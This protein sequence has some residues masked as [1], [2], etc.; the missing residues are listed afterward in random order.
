MV[1]IASITMNPAVDVSTTAPG[2]APTVKIRCS[3]PHVQ[4]GGGGINVAR[5]ATRF[6]AEA[7][8]LF[9]A[10]G[11]NGDHLSKLLKDEGVPIEPIP[12]A[13]DT[14]ESLTVTEAT[15]GDQYRFVFP[16]PTISP[17][18]EKRV[19]AA[20]DALAA[21][22]FLVVSGSLPSGLSAGFLATL[23][24]R[25]AATGAKLVVDGPAPVV[26]ASRGAFLVKPN[27]TELEDIVGA[28]LPDD[29][30]RVGAARRLIEQGIS[31]IVL[32]S[33]GSDGA[34]LVSDDAARLYTS[35]PVDLVSA[36]GAGDS[37]VGGLL[38]GLAHGASLEDAVAMGVAAGA[39]AILTPDTELCRPEDARRLLADVTSKP[40]A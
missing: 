28:P 38:V 12:I 19:L 17:E 39:A 2:I 8:A 32:I 24:E 16:G 6:G 31:T 29:G 34:L 1:A 4:A 27:I 20:V 40:V 21:P 3:E 11:P 37:M 33:L 22:P 23:A 10:G 13:A 7:L 15:S 5:V 9:T 36:V 30:A 14:R 26:K 18:E 25:A 35:P